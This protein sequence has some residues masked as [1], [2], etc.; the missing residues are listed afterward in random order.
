MKGLSQ[1]SKRLVLL[2]MTI[3]LSLILLDQTALP[4]IG[5]SLHANIL[6][7]GWVLNSYILVIASL[8]IFGGKLADLL[9][10]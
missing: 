9:G 6:Q 7:L 5:T 10:N 8:I 3:Y 2:S 4:N 1:H